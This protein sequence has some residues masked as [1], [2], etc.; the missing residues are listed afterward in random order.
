MSKSAKRRLRKAHE[1]FKR[2]YPS[3]YTYTVVNRETKEKH[4]FIHLA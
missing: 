2:A 1:A 3:S 4:H